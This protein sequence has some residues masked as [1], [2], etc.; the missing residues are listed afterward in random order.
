MKQLVWNLFYD[1][2]HAPAH[3]DKKDPIPGAG[4]EEEKNRRSLRLD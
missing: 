1:G 2:E 4:E 3:E